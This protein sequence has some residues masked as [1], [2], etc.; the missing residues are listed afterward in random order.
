MRKKLDCAGLE[1]SSLEIT[2]TSDYYFYTLA[3]GYFKCLCLEKIWK[4]IHKRA[5]LF[6]NDLRRIIRSKKHRGVSVEI[7]GDDE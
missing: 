2:E 7:L 6:R 4:R 1:S 5:L 3:Q